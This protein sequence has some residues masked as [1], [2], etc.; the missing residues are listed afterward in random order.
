M[1]QCDMCLWCY[2]HNFQMQAEKD[3]MGTIKSLFD[4]RSQRGTAYSSFSSLNIWFPLTFSS[5]HFISTNGKIRIKGGQGRKNMDLVP[6]SQGGWALMA[7]SFCFGYSTFIFCGCRMCLYIIN[8]N[9]V[10][11]RW[12]PHLFQAYFNLPRWKPGAEN[13]KNFPA[14]NKMK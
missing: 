13:S 11:L 10:C 5:S 1:H 2:N 12:V 4:Y 6:P 7:H 9:R 8:H 3:W 14:Q